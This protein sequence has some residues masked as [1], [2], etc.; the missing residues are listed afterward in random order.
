MQ[1]RSILRALFAAVVCGP[2]LPASALAADGE[3][4]R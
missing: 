4:T 1:I 2:L 3:S